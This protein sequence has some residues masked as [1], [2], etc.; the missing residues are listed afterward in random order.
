[1]TEW[2]SRIVGHGEEAPGALMPNPGNWR[3]HPEAQRAALAGALSA[4]GWVQDVIVNRTT[5]RIV[6]GHAR[7]ELAVAR[8]ESTVPVVY[9]EL[10]EAEE[11]VVL[12]TL[13]PLAALATTD[14]EALAALLADIT[15]SDDALRAMLADM[16][17]Q[18]PKAGLT[19]PDDV[20]PVP[21]EPTT[22]P[23]DLWLLGE[24]RLLC[25]DSTKAEDVARLLDG[26]TPRLCVTDPPYGVEYDPSWRQRAAAEGHLADAAR[27]IGKVTNDDRADWR[28]TWAFF[29]GDVSVRRWEQY[30]GRQAAR[31]DTPRRKARARG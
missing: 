16:Q 29:P 18:L 11:R 9:V 7:V 1:M 22:K 24:H 31:E 8:G 30:T 4:V 5:G 14:D 28:E 10:D 12:A 13:D 25:G 26:A 20:P 27:R 19:D 17:P 6:D 23:G 3:R 21:E 15:V 2:R